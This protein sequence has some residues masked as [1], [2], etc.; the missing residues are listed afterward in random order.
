MVGQLQ[1]QATLPLGEWGPRVVLDAVQIEKSQ[2][3]V[4]HCDRSVLVCGK[5]HEE[6]LNNL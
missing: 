1:S 6:H 5:Q 4:W 3:M 2:I